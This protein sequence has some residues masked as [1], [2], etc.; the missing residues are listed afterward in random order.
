MM[1]IKHDRDT[2]LL[3]NPLIEH[4]RREHSDL[5]VIFK[6]KA[7]TNSRRESFRNFA[8]P[9]KSESMFPV[10]P[11]DMD[12]DLCSRATGKSHNIHDVRVRSKISN[13]ILD[14][15]GAM[16]TQNIVLPRMKRESLVCLESS[17]SREFQNFPDLRP[18]RKIFELILGVP[19]K[20]TR[21]HPEDLNP[22]FSV[23]P[24]NLKKIL[25]VLEGQS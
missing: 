24:N 4:L 1:R 16:G 17:L 12:I 22:L 6:G 23:P 21:G 7:R 15:F 5:V 13:R 25:A 19:R 10:S 18:V 11:S 8:N 20:Q 9:L 3:V 2:H 14:H